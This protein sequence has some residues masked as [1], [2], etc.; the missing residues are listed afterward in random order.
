MDH[1]N[2][3]IKKPLLSLSS[4]Y[5]SILAS[6]FACTLSLTTLMSLTGSAMASGFCADSTRRA[7]QLASL[8]LFQGTANGYQ[9]DRAP[10]RMQGLVMLICLLGLEQEAL[11]Y[12]GD[13]PFTD[14]TWGQSYAAYAYANGLTRGTSAAT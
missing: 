12:S 5:S 2:N 1:K 9:L 10:T 8:H 4:L 14:L 7:D 11:D 6:I 3:K 13:S